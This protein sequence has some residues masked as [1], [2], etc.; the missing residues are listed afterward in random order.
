ME[1]SCELHDPG[2]LPQGK[3]F[4][5]YWVGGSVGL[6]ASLNT[7]EKRKVSCLCRESILGYISVWKKQTRTPMAYAK[8]KKRVME[9]CLLQTSSLVSCIYGPVIM[10]Y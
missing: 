3:T 4:G 9:I 5:T 6:R 10:K 2:A 1:V 8:E 7:M